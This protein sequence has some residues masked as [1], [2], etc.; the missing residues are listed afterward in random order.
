MSTIERIK[1]MS[2]KWKLMLPVIAIMVG[3]AIANTTWVGIKVKEISDEQSKRDLTH[4]S[5]T[6]FGVMTSYMTTGMMATH[7]NLFLNT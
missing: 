1:E 4:M 7:K 6:V 3:I 5:E 2:I